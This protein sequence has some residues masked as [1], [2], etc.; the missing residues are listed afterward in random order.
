M[1][2]SKSGEW[3][4]AEAK[5]SFSEVL[6]AAETGPQRILNRNRIVGAVIDA[7]SLQAFEKWREAQA[8]PLAEAF[9]ELRAIGAEEGYTLK[10][11]QRR[12]R[13]NAL[14]RVLARAPR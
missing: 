13:A 7:E 10:V 9:A 6:R 1:S 11:G 12:D 3:R 2:K 5:Q 14:A 4:V 8:R